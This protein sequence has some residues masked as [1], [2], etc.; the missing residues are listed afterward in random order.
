MEYL[1]SISPYIWGV[2]VFDGS[3]YSWSTCVQWVLLFMEYLYLMG[4]YI[5]ECFC[6]MGPYIHGVLVFDGSLYSWSTCI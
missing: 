2:I 6:S 5:Y 3:L 1:C 4:P